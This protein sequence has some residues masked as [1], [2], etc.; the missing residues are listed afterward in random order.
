[1]DKFRLTAT[2]T[3]PLLMHNGRLS[4]PLDPASKAVK[5]LVAK[6]NKTDEDYLELA[7]TEYLGGLYYEPEIGPY[8]P[9]DNILRCLYDAAKKHKQGPRV[10]EG[11]FITS[12]VN[13]LAYNGP[14]DAE[15]LLA[16]PN[17]QFNAM[18]KVNGSRVRRTRPM[19]RQW[20]ADAEG[21]LDPAVLDPADFQRCVETAGLFIG[22]GD[23]RPRYGRFSAQVESL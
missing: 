5:K 6:R 11:L 2:G 1:M 9:A 7:R 13:P 16:D 21:V 3:A 22:L 23:W 19:F 8:I 14:R 4:D 15:A 10:K 17:F 12:E 20:R 18:A